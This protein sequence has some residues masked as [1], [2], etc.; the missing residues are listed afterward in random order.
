MLGDSRWCHICGMRIPEDIASPDHGLYGTVDHV[1]PKSHNPVSSIENRM[2]AHR[3][4]NMKK[5]S[6]YPIDNEFRY[7][8][9]GNVKS[10]MMRNPLWRKWCSINQLRAARVRVGLPELSNNEIR[11]IEYSNHPLSRWDDDGGMVFFAN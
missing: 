3:V 6:H 5:G 7:A 9:Q 2:P 11:S 1:I 10:A 8:V 4:C